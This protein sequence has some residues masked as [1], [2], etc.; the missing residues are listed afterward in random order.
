[1]LGLVVYSRPTR[2]QRM[3]ELRVVADAIVAGRMG[4]V[5]FEYLQNT[6]RRE[7]ITVRITPPILCHT[8][9]FSYSST[10]HYP[11]GNRAFLTPRFTATITCLDD[12]RQS[13]VKSLTYNCKV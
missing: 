12:P 7:H 8:P 6:E 10:W 5:G 3:C 1:M 13:L 2:H 9:S 11:A 4:H